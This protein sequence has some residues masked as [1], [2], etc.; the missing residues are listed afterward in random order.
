MGRAERRRIVEKENHSRIGP[1]SLNF[2]K[3]AKILIGRVYPGVFSGGVIESNF[4]GSPRGAK[5]R[6]NK[7]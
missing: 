7:R 5:G 2:S 4:L 6:Y 1:D 3:Y